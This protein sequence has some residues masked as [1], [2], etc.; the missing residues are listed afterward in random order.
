MSPDGTRVASSS[1]DGTVRVWRWGPGLPARTIGAKSWVTGLAVSPDGSTVA[2]A[3]PGD[4]TFLVDLATGRRA[5]VLDAAAVA[6]PTYAPDGSAVLVSEYGVPTAGVRLVDAA[7]GAVRWRSPSLRTVTEPD[8]TTPDATPVTRAY[9]VL[10]SAFSADGSRIALATELGVTVLD[11][12]DGHLLSTYVGEPASHNLSSFLMFA[13]VR[14]L[15]WTPDG[16][17]VLAP[18]GRDVVRLDP[19]TGAET[20]RLVGHSAD[21]VAVAVLPGGRSVVSTSEDGTARVSDMSSGRS[22]RVLQ[23]QARVAAVAVSP[24]GLIATTSRDGNVSVWGPQ[25]TLLMRIRVAT[26]EATSVA[27]SSDGQSLLVGTGEGID[28]RVGFGSPG[29]LRTY[30]AVQ[31][32]D[33]PVCR[34]HDGLV[35]LARQHAIRTMTP[36]QIQAAVGGT[37]LATPVPGGGSASASPSP[38]TPAAELVGPWAATVDA[39]SLPPDLGYLAGYVLFRVLPSG[40]ALVY[41]TSSGADHGQVTS[42]GSTLSIRT[43]QC[44]GDVGTYSW[45]VDGSSLRLTVQKDPCPS[46]SALLTAAPLSRS[47]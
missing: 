45:T 33:C 41:G 38:A 40:A 34:D 27:W 31:V 13:P 24:S 44:G 18:D 15:A 12:G 21:V 11:A 3:A 37:D 10:G 6:A 7:T 20:A 42:D 28:E 4:G 22:E 43:D 8:Y 32:L 16:T 9:G 1:E 30:G 26:I 46:R 36:E 47:S 23:H 5:R 35:A 25:G 2:A 19:A 17:A 39:A 14:G 29:G